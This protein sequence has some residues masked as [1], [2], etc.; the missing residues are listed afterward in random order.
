M[1]KKKIMQ[2]NI[3]N[4]IDEFTDKRD[5][6]IR[7]KII[8]EKPDFITIQ[9]GNLNRV[10]KIIENTDYKIASFSRSEESVVTRKNYFVRSKYQPKREDK[11]FTISVIETECHNF[12]I[13]SIHQPWG[14]G[15]ES[16][17]VQS[18][19]EIEQAVKSFASI[20]PFRIDE[21]GDEGNK[22]I[23]ILG[24][25]FNAEYLADSMQ[26][27]FG[28]RVIDGN[29]TLYRDAFEL[30]SSEENSTVSLKNKFA[31]STANE[32]GLNGWLPERRIDYILSRGWAYGRPGAFSSYK[33][34]GN[35]KNKEFSDHYGIVAEFEC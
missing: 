35:E 16:L 6:L 2:V 9:E 4:K 20:E 28:N 29:S 8:V 32:N 33:I 5:I 13:T 31:R 11:K 12:A 26:F 1:K 30:N 27:L 21:N 23:G 25:D 24:G 10:E 14:S 34:I 15:K 3:L 17:R 18:I 22:I 19:L 7:E